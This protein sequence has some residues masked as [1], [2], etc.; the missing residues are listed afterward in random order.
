M[1]VRPSVFI[2]PVMYTVCCL[3]LEI[4]HILYYDVFYVCFVLA[5]SSLFSCLLVTVL[6][7]VWFQCTIVCV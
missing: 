3:L 2:V 7:F 1:L 5:C 6:C 4:V